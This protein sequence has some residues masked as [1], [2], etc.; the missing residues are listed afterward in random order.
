M[1]YMDACACPYRIL[2]A[3]G[4]EDPGIERRL[5]TPDGFPRL[6]YE[7]LR[8]PVDADVTAYYRKLADVVA[9]VTTP[10]VMLADNDDFLLLEPA[11][12]CCD[13]LDGDAGV[14][15]CGGRRVVLRVQSS[16]KE[17]LAVPRG[18]AYEAR[19]DERPK[20]VDGDTPA[21]RMSYFLR[22]VQRHCL[23]SCWYAVHR[24]EALA[25][26][27]GFAQRHTFRDPVAHELHVHLALLCRGRYAKQEAWSLVSQSG[28][29]Q[30][31]SQLEARGNILERFIAVNAFEDLQQSM[32][33]LAQWVPGADRDVVTSALAAWLAEIAAR[34]YPQPP[35]P[36]PWLQRWF[37]RRH[38]RTTVRLPA[39]EPFILETAS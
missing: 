1:R 15:S 10:Y 22:H 8:Y 27:L 35:S 3:D 29:S 30:L 18:T 17:L 20:T 33:E 37:R 2:I 25:A 6:R 4:G 23:W 39:I 5:R 9:R 32:E 11:E 31:T 24:T 38:P 28:A 14:V 36:T 12:G 34:A 7:Y 26:A 16:T 13:A 21:A 19:L